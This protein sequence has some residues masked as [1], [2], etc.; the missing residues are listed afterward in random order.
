MTKPID[1]DPI[2]RGRSFDADII[3]RCC[4]WYATEFEKGWNRLAKGVNSSW[5]VNKTYIKI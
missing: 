3:E 5:R 2:C 1:R 4:R